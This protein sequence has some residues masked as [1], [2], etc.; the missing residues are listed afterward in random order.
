LATGWGV[1][2]ILY[3]P[4]PSDG[5]GI[6][7]GLNKTVLVAGGAD[8]VGAAVNGVSI[9]G[10][11]IIGL[12]GD[13]VTVGVKVCAGPVGI[14]LGL[15]VVIDLGL[16]GCAMEFSA[17]G[18]GARVTFLLETIVT[19]EVGEGVLWNSVI[20]GTGGNIIVSVGLNSISSIA[21]TCLLTLLVCQHG[22]STMMKNNY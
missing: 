11:W 9:F 20:S 12:F 13:W 17:L 15:L 6:G 10:L 19:G 22:Q 4:T 21:I 5:L 18:L 7:T 14:A 16:L 3:V 1:P 2:E 8:A